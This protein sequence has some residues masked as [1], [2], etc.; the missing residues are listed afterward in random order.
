M[1]NQMQRYRIVL[2]YIEHWLDK[3]ND[4]TLRQIYADLLILEREVPALVVHWLTA[5]R[6]RSF[7]I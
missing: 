1:S 5:S 4:A 7:I 6:A 3:Q 2:D